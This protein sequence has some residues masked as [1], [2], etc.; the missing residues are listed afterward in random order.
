MSDRYII[1]ID[2]PAGS[3]KSTAARRLARRLGIHYFNSGALYRAIT[4]M[5][6]EAGI[7]LDDTDALLVHLRGVRI[8]TRAVEGREHLFLDGR[9][10]TDELF[11]NRISR[12][13]YLVADAPAVR[14][15][16]GRLARELNG[17]RSF[18]TEG[19]DQG[20]EV[21]AEARVKFY[22]DAR[23]EVRAERRRR[24]LEQRGESVSAEDV[25][26]DI[27]ERDERDRSRK[28]GALRPAPD[29][30]RLDNSDLDEEQT[31]ERLLEL[32]R[33][34]LGT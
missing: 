24:E 2:G 5:G 3:G 23:P 34:R 17:D 18:V 21:F 28:V 8:E 7:D 31:V 33:G 19:R 4:W 20:T 26:R 27:R 30:I 9:D 13:V 22:L 14:C 10:I 12:E 11:Q 6:L 1:T 29:A 15:E 32:A 25:L 16:V